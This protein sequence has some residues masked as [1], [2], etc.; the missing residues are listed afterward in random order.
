MAQGIVFPE[1]ICKPT[2][3]FSQTNDFSPMIFLCGVDEAGRGPLAGPVTAACVAYGAGVNVPS[4]VADSKQLSAKRRQALYPKIAESCSAKSVVSIGPRRI[5]ELNIR[6][7]AIYAMT[8]AVERVF[9]TLSAIH[10]SSVSVYLLIDGDIHLETEHPQES[11]I[12][13]DSRL[14]IIGAASILAKVTRDQLMDS[15][16]V[17]YPGYGFEQHKGY[18]TP[19]HREAIRLLSPSLAHRRSFAGVREHLSSVNQGAAYRLSGSKS[20][21]ETT[22]R[23]LSIRR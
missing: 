4:G 23:E 15:L 13:G 2:G 9:R 6:N 5:E 18:P 14:R 3:D 12:K 16:A 10:G 7:A 20:G 1:A 22:Q 19:S 11:I 8:L 17:R 21:E